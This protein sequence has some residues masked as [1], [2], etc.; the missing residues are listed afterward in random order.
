MIT[1]LLWGLSVLVAFLGGLEVGRWHRRMTMYLASIHKQLQE[2]QEAPRRAAE[3]RG[4]V[5]MPPTH[6]TIE[7]PDLEE[8]T[9]GVLPMSPRGVA[10]EEAKRGNGL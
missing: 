1:V 2:R 9:G 4:E 3:T 5:I 7:R 10:L 6:K 8:E